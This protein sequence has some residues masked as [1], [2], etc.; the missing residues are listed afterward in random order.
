M[1]KNIIILMIAFAGFMFIGAQS[2]NAQVD[3]TIEINW[4]DNNCNCGTII[5]KQ[6]R[7]IVTD[8]VTSTV[9]DDSGWYKVTGTEDIY[10]SNAA[11]ILDTQDR[12]RVTVAIIYNDTETICCSGG[13]IKVCDGDEFLNPIQ[14]TTITLY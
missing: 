8:I 9:L 10:S 5:A 4:D 11:I 2:V 1:K 6:A 7:V 3:Y 13:G 14:L 12:Y